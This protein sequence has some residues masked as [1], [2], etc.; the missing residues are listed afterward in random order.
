M[1]TW[2][3][4]KLQEVLV[5][6]ICNLCNASL[7]HGVFPTS[8]KQA[9]VL[10]RLKKSTLDPCNLASYRPI[11]NLTLISKV[12]ER[13]VTFRLVGHAEENELLPV[14]QSSYRRSHSTETAMM[15]MCVH[16]DL[17]RAVDNKEVTVLVLLDLSSAFD[18]V[19]HATLLNVL[20][21][22]LVFKSL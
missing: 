9:V 13:T 4:K 17:V 2:L 10:P 11:S 18:T 6:V 8:L 15:M 1:P 12:V 22:V 5:P 14:R 20:I 7:Q 3:V 21:G 19:D 16:N